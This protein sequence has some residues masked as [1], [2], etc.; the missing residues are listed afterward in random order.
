[1][2]KFLGLLI[3]TAGFAIMA[4]NPT[5]GTLGA[6]FFLGAFGLAVASTK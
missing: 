2:T 1:M 6:F 4:N 3:I 5:I